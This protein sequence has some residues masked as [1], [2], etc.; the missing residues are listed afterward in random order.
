LRDHLSLGGDLTVKNVK[1]GGGLLQITLVQTSD[2]DAGTLTLGFSEDPLSLKKWRIVDAQG[3]ITEVELSILKPA[4]R[5]PTAY[6]CIK[7]RAAGIR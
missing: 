7:T 5:T 1:H 6:S 2:P 3:L 4:S